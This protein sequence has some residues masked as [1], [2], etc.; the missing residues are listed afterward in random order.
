MRAV[1]SSLVSASLLIH[2]LI[3]CCWQHASALQCRFLAAA[4]E[5][6]ECCHHPGDGLANQE[7]PGPCKDHSNCHGLCTYLPAP[8]SQLEMPQV[9]VPCDF[10]A[11]L[12]VAIGSQFATLRTMGACEPRNLE[13]PLRLHLL[14]QHLLI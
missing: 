2:A 1:F 12:P 14:H 9:L 11:I 3:G 13:P 6:D 8:K 5:L 10:A 7:S 4:V